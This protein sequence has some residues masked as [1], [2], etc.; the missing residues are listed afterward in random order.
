MGAVCVREVELVGQ[1]FDVEL[2]LPRRSLH[3]K[4]PRLRACSLKGRG[5]A[6]VDEAFVLE[7]EAEADSEFV[8]DLV[9]IPEENMCSGNSRGRKI[10]ASL[11]AIE[12][13]AH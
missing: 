12:V 10:A 6:V 4:G 13:A 7:G 9:A 1:V 11:F 2:K 5:V 8:R 3:S